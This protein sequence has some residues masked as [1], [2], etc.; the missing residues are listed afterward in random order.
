MGS[1]RDSAL[2]LDGM[3]G[4]SALWNLRP[5][6][7]RIL[8]IS[9]RG[10]RWRTWRPFWLIIWNWSF[11]AGRRILSRTCQESLLTRFI[12]FSWNWVNQSL[13][14]LMRGILFKPSVIRKEL[15]LICLI[16]LF[17]KGKFLVNLPRVTSFLFSRKLWKVGRRFC[18]IMGTGMGGL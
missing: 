18:L 5:G 4:F 11:R 12:T 2:S 1:F 8:G 6:V 14:L 9:M 7:P 10:T 17:L 15:S 13:R 16:S 3:D